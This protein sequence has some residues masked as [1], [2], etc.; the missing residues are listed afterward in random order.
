MIV[1]ESWSRDAG[2]WE[3]KVKPE[4]WVRDNSVK[5]RG[6]IL[7]SR[8]DWKAMCPVLATCIHLCVKCLFYLFVYIAHKTRWILATFGCFLICFAMFKVNKIKKCFDIVFRCFNFRALSY[9]SRLSKCNTVRLQCP[10]FSPKAP[11]QCCAIYLSFE[12]LH[13]HF[14][15]IRKIH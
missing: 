12:S 3:L 14:L 13:F 4:M 10:L 8:G 7:E 11:L 5:C 9:Q 15:A 1:P 6:I 2:K